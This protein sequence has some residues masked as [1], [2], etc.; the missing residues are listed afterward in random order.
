[1]PPLE[2]QSEFDLTVY[3]SGVSAVQYLVLSLGDISTDEPVLVRVHRAVI[4]TDVFGNQGGRSKNLRALELIEKEGRGVFVYVLPE[5]LDLSQQL[6]R[7]AEKQQ[8][9]APSLV[10]ELREFGLGAQV[11]ATLGLKEIRLM[12]DNEKRIVGLDGYG[13]KVVERVPLNNRS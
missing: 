11:L 3:K 7:M 4:P 2:L 12:T 1:M 6:S 9:I 8:G 5:G 13:L 10:P